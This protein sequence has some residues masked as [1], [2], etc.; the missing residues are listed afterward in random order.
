M[1]K[2]SN[3]GLAWKFRVQLIDQGGV[4]T[5]ADDFLKNRASDFLDIMEQLGRKKVQPIKEKDYNSASE[6]DWVDEESNSISHTE[7][8]IFV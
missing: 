6:D 1:M 2:S 5:V 8:V 7:E 3:S 4:L